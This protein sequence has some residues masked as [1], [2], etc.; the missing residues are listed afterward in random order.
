MRM[1]MVCV[2]A[3]LSLLL[4]SVTQLHAQEKAGESQSAKQ[5]DKSATR[6]D[7]DERNVVGWT[8]LIRRELLETRKA[9][10]DKALHLLEQQL[11]EIVRVVPAAAV[12]ELK[13]VPLYFSPQYEGLRPRAEFHPDAG[14]LRRHGRDPDMARA[15]EFSNI[16]VF[17]QETNRMPNFT[18]HEL[19][20][21]Y[22]HRVLPGGFGN[23]QLKAAYERAQESGTY[24]RVE[25][26]FGN[27]RPNTFERSYG[28]TNPMEYFAES[29]EAYFSRNDFFPFTRAELKQHDPQMFELLGELWRP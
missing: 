10:T 29:S 23:P 27:G 2:V 11:K 24:D 21:A 7:Y 26:W 8:L 4:M 20:H 17:E 22:H 9:E 6:F 12:V 5:T 15:V 28:M 25:R 19:A 3:G 13:K 18:L 16:E 14:W 1:Q